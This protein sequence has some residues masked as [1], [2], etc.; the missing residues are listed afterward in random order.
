MDHNRLDAILE[1]IRCMK[2]SR[3]VGRVVAI[4]SDLI[5]VAGLG[6]KAKVRDNVRIRCNGAED[7]LGE[8]VAV[9]EDVLDVLPSSSTAGVTL[10]AK[11]FLE[12][13]PDLR[14]SLSWLGRVI[15]PL[16][17]ALDGAPLVKGPIGAKIFGSAPEA[18]DRKP[19]GE[20]LETGYAVFNT[21]LPIAKG[22]RVGLFA[23]SGVGKT[24]LLGRFARQIQTDVVVIA[25]V[26]E[27]GRE[28]SEFVNEVLGP[29]GM[30][31]SVIVAATSDQPAAL[32]RQCAFSA[33][34][35]A[36]YFR[37]Q[38]KSV[39]YLADSITRLAEA[40]REIACASGEA[41]SFR[42]HPPSLVQTIT[43]LC[44][45]AGPGT[46]GTGDITAIFSVLVA[47]SDMEEP[48]ADTIRGVLDGH[49]LLER[50]IA[51]RGRFP[52]V[53]VLRSVSRS[54]PKCATDLENI[55]INK[56]R[57]LLSAYDQSET[58]IK[59]GLYSTGAD[60]SL[61]EAIEVFQELDGFFARSENIDIKTSFSLLSNILKSAQRVHNKPASI[62][63]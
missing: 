62:R 57:K 18:L 49:F 22:Q 11:V 29:E 44:E 17:R 10:G 63:I 41:P 31:R 16:G 13:S 23:G 33:M 19:I 20:R 32:R 2:A 21:L 8:V 9:S 3:S 54:L 14:P 1:E 50:Q 40:H 15:D 48:V 51:E 34:A 42:G 27:R 30:K 60:P 4:S 45:R 61:D 46:S 38:G 56:V 25:L 28:V 5:R 7:T 47:G 58:M 36:E 52:A 39:L 12:Q 55:Q 43:S 37:D 53:D 26:G 24:S 59:A 35:I 6:A